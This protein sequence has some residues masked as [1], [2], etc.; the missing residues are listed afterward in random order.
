MSVGENI[1]LLRSAKIDADAGGPIVRPGRNDPR[2]RQ[3]MTAERNHLSLVAGG[4]WASI[5][6][7][8]PAPRHR[9]GSRDAF[10]TVVEGVTRRSTRMAEHRRSARLEE[11]FDH[12]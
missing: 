8:R 1:S 4:A 10:G 12:G 2:P 6:S 9:L 11:D 7:V 3:T 5:V